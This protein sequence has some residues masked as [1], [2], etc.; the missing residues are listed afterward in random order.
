MTAAAARAAAEC[1]VAERAAAERA[2]AQRAAAER[3]GVDAAVAALERRVAAEERAA[4]AA[5][6][7]V[8][9][10]GGEDGRCAMLIAPGCGLE[11]RGCLLEADIGY[12]VAPR[13]QCRAGGC[14]ALPGKGRRRPHM[15]RRARRE[16]YYIRCSPPVPLQQHGSGGA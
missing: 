6:A 1:A 16:S 7:A 2:A 5:L 15:R 8:F 3:V 10:E 12:T 13:P 4:L 9:E 14:K 11:P